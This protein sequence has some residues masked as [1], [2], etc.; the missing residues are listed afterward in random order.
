MKKTFFEILIIIFLSCIAFYP[1]FTGHVIFPGNIYKG[2]PLYKDIQ[3]IKSNGKTIVDED[4]LYNTF[5]WAQSTE[6]FLRS[7]YPPLWQFQNLAGMPLLGNDQSHP[8]F[9]LE[10]PLFFLFSPVTVINISV[11]LEVITMAI[12][13]YLFIS[14]YVKNSIAKITGSL[15]IA[16]NGFVIAWLLW[17]LATIICIFPFVLWAIEK[18]VR[19]ELKARTSILIS[20]IITTFIGLA[21]NIEMTLIL[22][23]VSFLF[24]ISLLI[25]DK[26][27]HIKSLKFLFLGVVL[28]AVISGIQWYP[29]IIDL[30][31]SHYFHMRIKN[32]KYDAISPIYL[33]KFLYPGILGIPWSNFLTLVNTN[34]AETSFF[35][36][37]P[38][39]FLGILAFTNKERKKILI[40]ISALIVIIIGV[41]INMPLVSFLV[42]LPL[43]KDTL[44]HRIIAVIPIFFAILIAIGIENL[45]NYIKNKEFRSIKKYI[46]IF[47]IVIIAISIFITI[48]ILTINAPTPGIILGP[49]KS[50]LWED[51]LFAILA[52]IILCTIYIKSKERIKQIILFISIIVIT[53]LPLVYILNSYWQFVPVSSTNIFH[54]TN[55]YTKLFT[56]NNSYRVFSTWQIA[57]PNINVLSKF[58]EFEGYDPVIPNSY[59]KYFKSIAYHNPYFIFFIPTHINSN[60]TE[61]IRLASI[62]YVL[63]QPWQ[64]PSP[65]LIEMNKNTNTKFLKEAN[66]LEKEYNLSSKYT[67]PLYYLS[68]LYKNDSTLKN[69]SANSFS[70]NIQKLL[71]SNSKNTTIKKFH[72]YYIHIKNINS[73]KLKKLLS[74]KIPSFLLYKVTNPTPIVSI[75]KYIKTNIKGENNQI[76]AIKKTIHKSFA[77]TTSMEITHPQNTKITNYKIVGNSIDFKV[78]DNKRKNV[79]VY[80]SELYYPGWKAYDNGKQIKIFRTNGIFDG[81]NVKSKNNNIELIYKPTN[82]K[83]GEYLTLAGLLILLLIVLTYIPIFNKILIKKSN[84]KN[85]IKNNMN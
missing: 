37:L 28:G 11:L 13:G 45:F 20:A 85:P 83:V 4:V 14:L 47:S 69:S 52:V 78:L 39:F 42:D 32:T 36:A 24:L 77:V 57:P 54:P 73:A 63:L 1:L 30:L 18:T 7:G 79:F 12:G 22:L 34:F 68:F 26:K 40:W 50:I 17:P 19:E 64:T 74:T 5:P 72:K 76:N 16:F 62:K 15:I 67:N 6:T 46:L 38:A 81:I 59:T 82:F 53:M 35:V 75:P 66:Q 56:K 44:H 31:R 80:I 10:F 29:A 43:L 65:G 48:K 70:Q 33:V 9:P 41:A 55:K 51:I 21:G 8:Y 25:R 61:L 2:I 3:G 84:N 60:A 27:I 49:L 23:F 58:N 71:K